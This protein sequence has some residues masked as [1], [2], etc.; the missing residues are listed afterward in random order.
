M[1]KVLIDTNVYTAFKNNNMSIVSAFQELDLIALDVT[2]LA[3]LMSGFSLGSKMKQNREE[4]EEFLD[5]PRVE[6][7]EHNMTTADFYSQVYKNLREKG[8]PI[9]TNDIWI[10]SAAMQHGLWLF[11][12]DEHF[13]NV[14]GIILYS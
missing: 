6:I 5:S 2:V 13:K 12:L 4:L 8:T 1:R 14:P 11:T 3:E 10:A 9:P 7:I